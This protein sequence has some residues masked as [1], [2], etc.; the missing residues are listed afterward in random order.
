MCAFAELLGEASVKGSV[1]LLRSNSVV[2]LGWAR[3]V[4]VLSNVAV[5]H[6]RAC[7]LCRKLS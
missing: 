3:D 6:M 5:F 1:G 2:R 7:H 4:E